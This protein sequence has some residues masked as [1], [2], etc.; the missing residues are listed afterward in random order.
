MTAIEIR[1]RRQRRPGL[2]PLYFTLPVAGVLGL[3]LVAYGQQQSRTELPGRAGGPPP[4]AISRLTAP[5]QQLPDYPSPSVLEAEAAAV[6]AEVRAQHYFGFDPVGRHP[7]G[8]KLPGHEDATAFPL[9]QWDGTSLI[10]FW[11]NNGP[12]L[13]TPAEYA[14]P[15][16][17]ADKLVPEP[18][19][20][21]RLQQRQDLQNGGPK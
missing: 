12:R 14:D 8:W 13:I 7:M 3:A 6:P 5:R 18:E 11:I 2:R 15:Q 9:F 20:S 21:R 4:A 19:R 17:D 16:F 1:T 10:G